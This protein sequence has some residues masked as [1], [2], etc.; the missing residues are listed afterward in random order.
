MKIRLIM[1]YR[2][3]CLKSWWRKERNS[4]ESS[5]SSTISVITSFISIQCAASNT[6][7]G[8]AGVFT[9]VPSLS[10]PLSLCVYGRQLPPI[11]RHSAAVSRSCMPKLYALFF[12]ATQPQWPVRTS[13]LFILE[14]FALAVFWWRTKLV[15]WRIWIC[16][17]IGCC[18]PD[19]EECA[20]RIGVLPLNQ[21]KLAL[22]WWPFR[23]AFK[24]QLGGCRSCK[25]HLV[26]VLVLLPSYPLTMRLKF[27]Q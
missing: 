14:R 12:Q 6:K 7:R 2:H 10:L 19:T 3:N 15:E 11:Q 22:A 27:C 21:Q 23:A 5:P 26:E 8:I 9:Q 18:L 24:Q 13:M 25:L 20:C 4:D 17:V 1:K 16:V